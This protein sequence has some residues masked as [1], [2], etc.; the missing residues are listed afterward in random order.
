MFRHEISVYSCSS[1]YLTLTD[2]TD[3]NTVIKS[4]LISVSVLMSQVDLENMIVDDMLSTGAFRH[5]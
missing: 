5:C 2:K 4:L 3:M 1:R